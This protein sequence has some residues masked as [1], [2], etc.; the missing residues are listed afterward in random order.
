M[1]S[2]QPRLRRARADD[3]PLDAPWN[4]GSPDKKIGINVPFPEPLML[5]LDYLIEHRSITSKSSFIRDSVAAAA[6]N[7]IQKLRRLQEAMRRIEEEDR[8]KG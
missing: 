2:K 6:A 7:E 3:H 4:K 5:Q 8:E 1:E